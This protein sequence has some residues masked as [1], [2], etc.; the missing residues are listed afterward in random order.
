MNI[1]QETASE[2]YDILV[3]ECGASEHH[4]EDFCMAQAE[5]PISEW[6]FMGA[7]GFGGKFYRR[8][9]DTKWYVDCYSEERTPAKR[10]MIETANERLEMFREVVRGQVPK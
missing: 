6:R 9:G 5:E 8:T 10:Q 1:S 7:L 2:I 4:R 3:Q